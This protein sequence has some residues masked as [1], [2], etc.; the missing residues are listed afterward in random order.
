MSDEPLT[1]VIPC[2]GAGT[3]L[4][5]VVGRTPKV[6]VPIGGRP[7]LAHLFDAFASAG[8][9]RV[10]LLAGSGGAEVEAAAQSMAPSGVQ[11]ETI[12]E[13]EPLGTAGALA[14][15]GDRLPERFF[16]TFGDLYAAIDWNRLWQFALARGGL[17][18]LFVHR[19]S[20]PEDSDVLALSDDK[21]VTGWSRRGEH[22]GVGAALSNAAVGVF[23]R[24][25]LQRIPR[26]RACDLTGE[27]LPALVDARAPLFG[28]VSSEYVC[29]MGTPARLSS[30]D[31]AVSS[32]RATLR[33]EMLLLDRDGVITE[34]SV[35][36]PEDLRLLPGAADSIRQLREARI[37]VSVVTN[38]AIVAR[39]SCTEAT[40]DA[41]H[42]RLRELLDREGA[43]VDGIYVCPHHPETHHPEGV[44]ELRGP[45]RCRKPSTGLAEQALTEQGIP[46][47]R[48][49]VVGDTTVDAQLAHNA[50]LA[51]AVVGT[52]HGGSDGRHPAT[53]TWRFSGLPAVSSWVLGEES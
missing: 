44:P 10:V 9:Q 53:A 36:R 2:G 18:T 16:L 17:G 49:L 1:V 24:D 51:C 35:T 52:G 42:E 12:I 41:I 20:H 34:D 7:L 21:R 26:G 43:G 6:L 29:D 3:R 47:W 37:R 22:R 15:V 33:A 38:Q 28:Y 19:S 30:V 23:H 8:I 46:A 14:I 45:C 48:T 31:E 40:L 25:V 4:A 32:G 13:P 50:S 39:G 27:V 5:S 11:A